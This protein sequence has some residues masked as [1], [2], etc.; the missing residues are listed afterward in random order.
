MDSTITLTFG[1]RGESFYGMEIIGDLVDTGFSL[2]DLKRFRKYFKSKNKKTELINLKTK[3]DMDDAY[4]LII[5][6]AINT[7]NKAF[8]ELLSLDYDKKALMRGRVINKKARYNLCF[9][10]SFNKQSLLNKG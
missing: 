8:N 6:K 4:I 9:G 3:N 1:D 10:P 2:N 5:R 7:P